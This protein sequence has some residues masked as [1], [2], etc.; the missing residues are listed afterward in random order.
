MRVAV[1]VAG[2]NGPA[3][4]TV[5]GGGRHVGAG[6]AR[7]GPELAAYGEKL[8]AVEAEARAARRGMRGMWGRMQGTS[9]RRRG[10]NGRRPRRAG[11]FFGGS[12][13]GSVGVSDY[14]CK[15]SL[16]V[17]RFPGSARA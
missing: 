16:G 10:G 6:P 7:K 15:R 4:G 2:G 3:G 13:R 8:K 17:S 14:V 9:V 1:L 12:R 5:F 11:R